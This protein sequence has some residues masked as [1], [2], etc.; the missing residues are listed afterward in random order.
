MPVLVKGVSE[1]FRLMTEMDKLMVDSKFR[2]SEDVVN[3]TTLG[4]GLTITLGVGR[5]YTSDRDICPKTRRE[6]QP[7]QPSAAFTRE[8]I[9]I[10]GVFSLNQPDTDDRMAIV[11]IHLARNCSGTITR[12]HR[13]T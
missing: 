8:E 10:G 7:G 6:C 5:I 13:S 12:S 3:Y 1:E 4:A 11:P 9:Q 2:L